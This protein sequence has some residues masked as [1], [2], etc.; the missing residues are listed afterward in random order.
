MV[1]KKE[2]ITLLMYSA[3]QSIHRKKI[4]ILISE[5][6]PEINLCLSDSSSGFAGMVESSLYGQVILLVLLE[7]EDDHMEIQGLKKI[8]DGH[9]VILILPD[10]GDAVMARGMSLYPRYM[11]YLKDDYH[12]VYGVLEKMIAKIRDQK[13]GED[14]G[15]NH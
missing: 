13:K 10:T 7:N 15:R 14:D 12:D 8:L 1:Q 4:Q 9:H 5:L 3:S 2:T 6:G 11:S